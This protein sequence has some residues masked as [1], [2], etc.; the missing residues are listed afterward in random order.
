VSDTLEQP[1]A[2]GGRDRLQIRSVPR[3]DGAELQLAG[4]LTLATL[5]AFREKLREIEA[6]APDLLVIDLRQL[7][8]VD[9]LALGELVATD[10]RSRAARRRLMLVTAA[11][12]VERVLAV[13]GLD[14]RLQIRHEP[15]GFGEP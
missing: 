13:T 10:R 4:E 12:P 11:G 3:A 1:E 14:G 7:R 8:F 15:P 2:R 9:S 5:N 6:E